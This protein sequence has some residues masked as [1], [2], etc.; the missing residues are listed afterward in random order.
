MAGLDLL[1]LPPPSKCWV[2]GGQTQA[3]K[4]LIAYLIYQVW[5]Q[6]PFISLYLP[7]TNRNVKLGVVAHAFNLA[8]R[9]R[10]HW[11]EDLC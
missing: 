5:K 8:P 10:R 7:I 6:G 11:Q 1:L 2:T 4:S 3:S 9:R